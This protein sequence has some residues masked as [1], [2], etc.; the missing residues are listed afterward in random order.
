[1]KIELSYQDM[2]HVAG[3]FARDIHWKGGRHE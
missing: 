1:M 3:L 2:H